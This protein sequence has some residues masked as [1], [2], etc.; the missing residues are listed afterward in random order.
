MEPN[1]EACK[2]L[3]DHLKRVDEWACSDEVIKKL[4]G[5][6]SNKYKYSPVVKQKTQYKNPVVKKNKYMH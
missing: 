2:Q 1:L 3:E 4:F 5:N 6:R